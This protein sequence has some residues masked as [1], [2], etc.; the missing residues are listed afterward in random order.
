M[1]L[2]YEWLGMGKPGN[3]EGASERETRLLLR[4]GPFLPIDPTAQQKSDSNTQVQ[5]SDTDQ[6]R[7]TVVSQFGQHCPDKDHAGKSQKEAQ[8]EELPELRTVKR[9]D[10]VQVQPATVAKQELCLQHSKEDSSKS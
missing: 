5:G 10:P 8:A 6:K 4:K 7:E 9:V 3:S 2:I 1:S